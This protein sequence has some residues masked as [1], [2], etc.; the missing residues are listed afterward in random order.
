MSDAFTD[1]AKMKKSKKEIKAHE[2]QIVEMTWK[3]VVNVKKISWSI[4]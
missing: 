2:G 1:A 4:N 3:M